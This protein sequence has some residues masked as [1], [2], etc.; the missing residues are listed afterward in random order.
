MRTP[1]EHF[2]LDCQTLP[3]GE[4]RPVRLTFSC[5]E[6]VVSSGPEGARRCSWNYRGPRLMLLALV[7]LARWW[8]REGDA[9]MLPLMA[10]RVA[11]AGLL[12]DVIAL[13]K[14][15]HQYKVHS[16][17]RDMIVMDVP[18]SDEAVGE[19]LNRWFYREN[20]TGRSKQGTLAIIGANREHLPPEAVEVWLDGKPATPLELD[21]I[22]RRLA[23]I[24]GLEASWP[25]FLP[26]QKPE[27]AG[28]QPTVAARFI[29]RDDCMER[30]GKLYK[31]ENSHVIIICAAGGQGKTTIALE[32]L[33]EAAASGYLRQGRVFYWPFYLQGYA[34]CC[35]QWMHDFWQKLGAALGVT[36]A[37]NDL[38]AHRA[39]AFATAMRKSPTLLFLDGLEVL[40]RR[41]CDLPG[42]I[43]DA[44]LAL[45]VE[46]IAYQDVPGSLVLATS[47]ELL[48][49]RLRASQP[50]VQ[51][52]YLPD[53]E[54]SRDQPAPHLPSIAL[55][56]SASAL[57][58]TLASWEAGA[59][60]LSE[61][62]LQL[63]KQ[64][65]AEDRLRTL[66][67]R[68]L[69]SLT[70]EV[71]RAILL[72][73]ALFDRPAE[74]QHLHPLLSAQPPITGLCPQVG[75]LSDE[76]WTS[77][78]EQ[79]LE[80]GMLRLTAESALEMHPEIRRCLADDFSR[81]SPRTWFA[82]Q[83][84]LRDYFAAIPTQDAP[85]TLEK[86][87]PLFRAIWHGVQAGETSHA[88][89]QIADAR[90][91]RGTS[92]YLIEELGADAE[93]L[94]LAEYVCPDHLSFPAGSDL[95]S[96]QRVLTQVSIAYVLERM[97]RLHEAREVSRVL[98]ERVLPKHQIDVVGPAACLVLRFQAIYYGELDGSMSVILRMLRAFLATPLS[99][100]AMR[101]PPPFI[102]VAVGWSAV[103]SA[104]ALWEMG[105]PRRARAVLWAALTKCRSLA[106]NPQQLLLSAS[107]RVW[108]ALLLLDMGEWET[109][110]RADEAGELRGID[111]H[112][113]RTGMDEW[114]RG[115]YRR[116]EAQL[117]KSGP[118]RQ[119]LA[120][121]A[122][123]H[124]NQALETAQKGRYRWQE[125][126]IQL[127]LTRLHLEALASSE[128]AEKHRF[129]CLAIAEAEGF[130]LILKSLSRIYGH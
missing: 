93:A 82:A 97:G 81:S 101:V 85:D 108:H 5:P 24:H 105:K 52:F 89:D 113:R 16:W 118:H 120:M 130:Q 38:P 114:V 29:R 2:R 68:R 102:A 50:A 31:R 27:L 121:C 8:G 23:A 92:A 64:E 47:R 20:A 11:P 62:L 122:Q 95:T 66:I 91:Y 96:N 94:T 25:P 17:L 86:M 35:G 109:V 3:G 44:A 115:A 67:R 100:Q 103:T 70:D 34:G 14:A 33:R 43:Q 78:L 99:A 112:S 77:A 84:W 72:G 53:L 37:D 9:E 30:L 71:Q 48:S 46:A 56:H 111:L 65:S 88:T 128:E 58:W 80:T 45:L 26:C 126:C 4:V 10:G 75:P 106:G 127:E 87:Q 73:A 22:E 79:V 40:L 90:I 21:R 28:Y 15:L 124:L 117:M 116:Q 7:R 60:P 59:G 42:G 119:E 107:S 98:W 49:G 54:Q 12:M 63:V 36:V 123:K 76:A 83:A 125:A 19:R 110:L 6:G 1:L 55:E 13:G 51:H 41:G 57:E 39:E 69:S 32:W 61:E 74:W 104:R 18:E 129:Q